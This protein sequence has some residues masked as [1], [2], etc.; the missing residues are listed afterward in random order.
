MHYREHRVPPPLD[1][2][3][4]CVWF[5]RA[6][7]A[8][9]QATQRVL[10]DGC[11]ELIVHLGD[12]FVSLADGSSP[13]PAS[14][15]VGMLTRPIELLPPAMVE[16]IG[17]RFR[18]GGAHR[19]FALPLSELTDSGLALEDLWGAT[20]RRFFAQLG[21]A[22]RDAARLRI[23]TRELMSRLAHAE[24]DS[25]SDRMIDFVLQQLMRSAGRASVSRLAS[26]AGITTRHLQRKFQQRVGVGPKMLARLLRFQNT[27]RAR[28]A[29]TPIEWARIAVECGYADQSH[30]IREY[31]ALAG[32]TPASLL[33][34][35]G[36]LSSYFTAPHR[37][38]ALLDARR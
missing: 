2:F 17:I 9:T 38:A 1:A 35:E 13:Q 11:I 6:S 20:G 27:L 30:L 12:A 34:A 8:D 18:P 15:V 31:T 21:D 32:E 25:D 3:V 10:P 36:E 28:T 7:G 37:L 22:A 33:A 5:L 26:S 19:F 23:I 16:T 29:N 14:L 4:E 24:S